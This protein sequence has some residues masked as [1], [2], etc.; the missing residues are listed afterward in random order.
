MPAAPLTPPVPT[1]P[2]HSNATPPVT[3][4]LGVS[5]VLTFSPF[6]LAKIHSLI[7]YVE[8]LPAT[9][10]TVTKGEHVYEE[11]QYVIGREPMPK[12]EEFLKWFQEKGW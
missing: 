1:A 3:G 10:S 9:R 4:D 8:S 12:K 7:H 11:L 6:T 5:P 2:T